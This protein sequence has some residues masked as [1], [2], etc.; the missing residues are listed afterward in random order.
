MAHNYE[1]DVLHRHE[2]EAF[3][4]KQEAFSRYES[5]REEASAAY[6]RMQTAWAERCAARDT[7]NR[8]FEAMKSASEAYSRI[9]EEFREVRDT[10][11]PRIESLRQEADYEHQ[12]MKNYFERA[13]AAYQY[14]D[15]A[16]AKVLSEEGHAHRERR[17]ALNEEVGELIREIKDAKRIA[18]SR[19]SKTDSSAYRSARS[20][21]D[22]AKSLHE[23]METEFKRLKA[24]R[25]S[26]KK[27]FDV[28]Q[29]IYLKAKD[30]FRRRLEEVKAAKRD[31][32]RRMTDKVNMALVKTKP[33]YLG[34]IFGHNAKV[35]P[36]D[37]GSG[38]TD[39]YF[40]GLAEAGDGL[41]HGHAVIDQYGNV[42][43][44]RD[45]WT[46]HSDYLI[47][48]RGRPTHNA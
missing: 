23:S 16:E 14:G 11:N 24:V 21:F 6:D 20:L 2:E 41:G 45:A 15:K 47:N 19:A 46:D 36:R 37:D 5:A 27:E 38:A 33:F 28:Y 13:S 8:E 1:L 22:K 4:R 10:N 48:D 43:Y 7:M 40:A 44:L 18:E 34:S 42:T 35:V 39:V 17:D 31:N 30:E 25:D 9:W 29:D 32:E 3:R 26:C 12:E